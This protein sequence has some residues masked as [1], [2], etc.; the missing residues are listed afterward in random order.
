ML[1]KYFT[2][3]HR[4]MT[5]FGGAYFYLILTLIFLVFHQYKI[6]YTLLFGFIS[7]YIIGFIIRLFYFKERPAKEKYSNLITKI[8]ASSF[9]SIHTARVMFIVLVLSRFFSNNLLTV[10]FIFI[11]L[12]TA[13]SRIYI[14]K[15]YFIDV[16]AGFLIGVVI[17]LVSVRLI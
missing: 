6:F 16:A 4:D 10:I 9:P 2:D 17:H 14:K 12:L 15:H 11:A 7:T 8:D 3:F 1:E 5:T 13:Y